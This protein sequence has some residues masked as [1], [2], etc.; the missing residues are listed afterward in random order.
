MTDD[1]NRLLDTLHPADLE[2]I[3]PRLTAITFERG[4]VL[5]HA[6]DVVRYAWFPCGPSL[7]TFVVSLEPGVVIEAAMVG[8]EGAVG[9][10]VSHGRLPAYADVQVLHGGPFFRIEAAALEEI[11][12]ASPAIANLFTRYADCLVAQMLQSVACN[13]GHTITQRTA[14]W[15]LAA[16]DR[17]GDH[18]VPLRQD[19]LA[20]MLGVGR[21]FVNRVLGTLR[22][23]GVLKTRRGA[24]QINDSEALKGLACSCNDRLLEHFDTV[25]AGVYPDPGDLAP[26]QS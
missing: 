2:R 13:A 6:G 23:A 14:K 12:L 11:K 5:H 10:I 1:G 22:E 4:H 19:Q 26:T 21:S 17:T 9:G 24:L 20:D 8:R 7:A 3:K 18:V 15:L 25:L 16:I